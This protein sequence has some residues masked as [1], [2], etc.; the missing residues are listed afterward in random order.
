MYD[1]EC[2]CRSVLRFIQIIKEHSYFT[3]L[4]AVSEDIL[5]GLIS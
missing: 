4:S 3:K 5:V 2:G 1:Y